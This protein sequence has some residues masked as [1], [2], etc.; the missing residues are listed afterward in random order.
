MLRLTTEQAAKLK[1]KLKGGGAVAGK[2]IAKRKRTAAAKGLPIDFGA[3]LDEQ[4]RTNGLPVGVAELMFHDERDWRFD[5]AWPDLGLAV[6]IE[7]GIYSGGRHTRGYGYEQDLVKYAEATV[8]GWRILRVSTGHVSR[9]RAV[10]WLR[11][12]MAL[13]PNPSAPLLDRRD[14]LKRRVRSHAE[15][16]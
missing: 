12:A 1:L 3:L 5:R 15:A 7:G 16:P 13:P 4:C 2:A 6:E 9:G 10:A 8:M 11:Q 14:R